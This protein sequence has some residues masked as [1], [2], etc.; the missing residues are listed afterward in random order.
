MPDA[1]PPSDPNGPKKKRLP[2][3]GADGT[4]SITS[5]QVMIRLVRC[6]GR[7]DPDPTKGHL[8]GRVPMS[9]ALWSELSQRVGGDLFQNPTKL[10]IMR[11]VERATGQDVSWE[12]F[13]DR[14]VAAMT[15]INRS[16]LER[17]E[18]A[19]RVWEKGRDPLVDPR[20]TIRQWILDAR[21][22]GGVS[23]APDM[24]HA[25]RSVDLVL[26]M[27]RVGDQGGPSD[28][29][30][31]M[32]CR[33]LWA[34]MVAMANRPQDEIEVADMRSQLKQSHF[35]KMAGQEPERSVRCE[36]EK[37][38]VC[39]ERMFASAMATLGL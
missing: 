21:L 26:G 22:A 33:Y 38:S 39:H 19:R 37:A 23:G 24:V 32:G 1:E 31:H 36:L 29:F 7:S 8:R 6:L 25:K 2:G 4:P 9:V 27:L 14:V 13:S 20:E 17:I 12:E 34:Y 15:A 11:R 16:K 5:R 3:M 10:E 30:F 18:M 35:G 28:V